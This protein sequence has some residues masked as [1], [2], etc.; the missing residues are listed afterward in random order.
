MVVVGIVLVLYSHYT[1]IIHKLYCSNCHF[2]TSRNPVDLSE[3]LR[4]DV[5]IPLVLVIKEST[6][7][8]WVYSQI[9]ELLPGL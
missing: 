7:A 8:I 5:V 1:T 9:L 6:S 2:V 3:I 4:L